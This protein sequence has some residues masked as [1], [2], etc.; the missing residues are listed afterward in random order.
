M[1]RA[2]APAVTSVGFVVA[3]FNSAAV[4][5][6]C[7]DALERLAPADAPI[8]VV[9]N[10]STDGTARLVA[11]RIPRARLLVSA[12][13]RGFAAA[14]NLGAAHLAAE[15]IVLVNPDVVL[16]RLDLAMFSVSTADAGLGLVAL[17]QRSADALQPTFRVRTFSGA[18]ENAVGFS[19][20]LLAPRAFR[21]ERLFWRNSRRR[22]AGNALA[23]SPCWASGGLVAVRQDA[24]RQIGGFDERYFLFH[25][26]V[27]LC[28][29]LLK[30]G[31]G[32]GTTAAIAGLHDGGGAA[33][34]RP[35]KLAWA[36]TSWLTYV[37]IWHGRLAARASAVF[38]LANLACLFV[39]VLAAA[40]FACGRDRDRW[41]RKLL[42]IGGLISGLTRAL[43]PA[44]AAPA[45]AADPSPLQYLRGALT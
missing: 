23:Q 33:G 12:R 40:P 35:W 3:T 36:V 31:W 24:W 14:C 5:D 42:Q 26:D 38:L 34:L 7:L 32:I 4:V 8:V 13:N 17:G 27:D 30:A 20:S 11:R 44:T 18:F 22:D 9:D 2:P 21:A 45:P 6:A 41:R 15:W 43:R 10:A 1:V 19:W 25:E 16:E 28:R 39:G 29:R 37:R